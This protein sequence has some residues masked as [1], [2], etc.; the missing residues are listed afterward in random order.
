LSNFFKALKEYEV[1]M[2]AMSR[3]LKFKHLFNALE[4]VSNFDG[5]KR[6][7]EIFDVHVAYLSGVKKEDVK[8]WRGLYNR[9]KHADRHRADVHMYAEGM[10]GIGFKYIMPLTSCCKGILASVLQSEI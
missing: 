2:T 5:G 8:E 4:L 3:P 10:K 1:A 7:K 9:T 6:E